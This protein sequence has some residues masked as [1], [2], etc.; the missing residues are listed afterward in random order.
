MSEIDKLECL[1]RLQDVLS[2]K[3]ELENQIE[4]L[5]ANLR[6]EEKV[7]EEET[8]KYQELEE[9]F[10][11]LTEEVK[12]LSIRYEDAFNT[13]TG[14]EKQMEFLNTQREY[15]ALSKQL[16]EARVQES[17]LLK[18][19]NSKNQ[20]IDI[21][22]SELAQQAAAVEAQKAKVD[23]ERGRIEG[24]LSDIESQIAQK[25]EEC[26]AI[27]SNNISED[28]YNKFANIVKKKKG[29]GIVPVYGQVCMG[30]D[31]VLPMQFVIDL[32][33]KMQQNEI[34]YCPYCSRIIYYEQLDEE[35]EKNYI[36]EQLEASKTEGK[37]SAEAA[38]GDTDSYDESMGMDEGFEDF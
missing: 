28:L 38:K 35:R 10:A 32:R 8:L 36:F 20:E 9:K 3:F 21:V 22:R 26:E 34:E 25:N 30:C 15:E 5:P 11:S 33:L 17:T 19:R 29:I 7:L 2:T 16:E 4:T 18:R 27:K 1:K 23:E 13:R 24:V 37:G 6:H 14:Y 12:S 31:R